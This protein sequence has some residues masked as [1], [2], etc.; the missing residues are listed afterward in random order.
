MVSVKGVKA[1]S[2]EHLRVAELNESG[3][4]LDALLSIQS[5]CSIGFDIFLMCPPM[6]PAPTM[7]RVSPTRR[8]AMQFAPRIPQTWIRLRK[9]IATAS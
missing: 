8:G 7:D 1:P 5:Q 6:S 3:C 9:S 2:P 4:V